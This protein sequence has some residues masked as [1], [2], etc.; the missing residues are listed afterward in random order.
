VEV[1]VLGL[2][3]S[4]NLKIG[5]KLLE[6]PFHLFL[7]GFSGEQPLVF[8]ASVILFHAPKSRKL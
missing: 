8:I 6:M 5:N 2:V 3:V 1:E 4:G 7:E